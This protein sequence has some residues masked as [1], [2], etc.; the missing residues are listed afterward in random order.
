MKKCGIFLL[1]IL[2]AGCNPGGPEFI[3]ELDVVYTNYD[4]DFNFSNN[5]TY[6]LPPGVIDISDGEPGDNPEYIEDAFSDAILDDIREN[7]TSQGWTE[8][9]EMENPDLIILASA[10]Q[11]TSIYFYDPGWWWW[12]YPGWGPGWG[13]GYPGYFPGYV[14][15]YSTGTVLIQMTDPDGIVSNEVP[16]VWTCAMNGLLEGSDQNIISRID[17]NIDRAFNHDPFN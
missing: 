11:R 5:Y 10:L 2:V 17:N 6:S 7:L 4:P 15:D 8:V 16:V 14:S 12:Y 1:I 9:D 3:E 13:W